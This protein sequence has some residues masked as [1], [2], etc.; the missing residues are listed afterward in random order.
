[1]SSTATVLATCAPMSSR[2]APAPTSLVSPRCKHE[3]DRQGRG[4]GDTAQTF[5]GL[6]GRRCRHR[7]RRLHP[8]RSAGGQRERAERDDR[9][10][11]CHRSR[12]VG[13]ARRSVT[14]SVVTAGIVVLD[15]TWEIAVHPARPIKVAAEA[16]RE[17]GGGM[18]AAAA[19][20]VA[21]LAGRAASCC[22]A[23][24]AEAGERLL[25]ELAQRNVEIA[26]VRPIA[27]S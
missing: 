23:G 16:Y 12:C 13:P 22:R 14:A 17:S 20:T 5:A 26:G 1:M 9:S 19:V 21:L 4:D 8:R 27:A 15:R 24:D 3:R 11:P 7:A 10:L 25:R 2:P 6:A 18:A